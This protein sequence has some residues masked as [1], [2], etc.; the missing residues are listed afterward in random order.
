MDVQPCP[1]ACVLCLASS[2]HVRGWR[3][4]QWA[5]ASVQTPV[6]Q[7]PL[8]TPLESALSRCHL[9]RRQ[10]P[11]PVAPS[12]ETRALRPSAPLPH[13]A[14][15]ASARSQRICAL[16]AHLG[17]LARRHVHMRAARVLRRSATAVKQGREVGRG[18]RAGY[19]LAP[20]HGSDVGAAWRER[21]ARLAQ[22]PLRRWWRVAARTHA[23]C[24][25]RRR[26]T[27]GCLRRGGGG[28][29]GA[30][31]SPAAS[32]PPPPPK[33][34]ATHSTKAW[35]G[36]EAPHASIRVS[37][38]ARARVRVRVRVRGLEWSVQRCEG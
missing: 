31:P 19:L 12:H 25:L 21:L 14:L 8:V 23:A 38:R 10:A 20:E 6:I 35:Q 16:S 32:P 22:R 27:D 37:K 24:W 17:A 3:L 11:A 33:A 1:R 2:P 9:W 36:A 29:G 28:G 15:S 26:R 7:L 4:Q 13:A 18:S 34:M 30:G 5:G